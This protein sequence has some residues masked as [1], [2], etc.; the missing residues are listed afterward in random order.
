[1]ISL[2]GIFPPLPTSFDNEENLLPEK[3]RFNIGRMSKFDLSGFLILGS[4]G[5]Q[6]MLSEEEK[7]EAVKAAKSALPAGK[8]LLAGTGGQSTRE[9]I[10]LTRAAAEAG[11][12]GVLVLNPFYF[13][14]QMTG[15]ALVK[16]YNNVAEASPVPVIVYNMPGNTGVDMSADM[17]IEMSHH[18]NIIG[19]K[20][21]GGN[22]VKIGDVIRGS[23]PGFQ[24]LAGGAGFLLPALAT[25]AVGGILALANIAP[26]R[27]LDI[28]S[29]FMK[30]EIIRAREIQ[31]KVI[32]VNSAITSQWGVP[33]LKE[34]MDYLGFYGGPARKPLMALSAPVREQLIKLITEA[35]IGK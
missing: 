33:A 8:I 9:T 22:V 7:R 30:G 12:D 11:A 18:E 32:P 3:I 13:K 20:E 19:L 14:S 17:I 23:K 29:Y 2:K 21:S 26:D 4:N 6:V 27:C 28:Y 10:R 34:A 16:H 1:M 15:P 31:H 5:E 35:G 24:V 25:G